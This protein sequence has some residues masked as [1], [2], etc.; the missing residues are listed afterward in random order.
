MRVKLRD[1]QTHEEAGQVRRGLCTSVAP[2]PVLRTLPHASVFLL[3][4]LA[5]GSENL[6]VGADGSLLT[7]F[8]KMLSDQK[9]I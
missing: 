9:T 3:L 2:F 4:S 8:L 6:K 7:V 1:G 5:Q